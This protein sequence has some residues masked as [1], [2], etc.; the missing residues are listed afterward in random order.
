MYIEFLIILHIEFPF[1][2]VGI[3]GYDF[4][5]PELQNKYLSN[6]IRLRPLMTQSNL[7]FIS[8]KIQSESNY[9]VN[10]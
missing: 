6:F 4:F 1:Y 3:L 9:D 7:E 2:T 10:P 8:N 5:I